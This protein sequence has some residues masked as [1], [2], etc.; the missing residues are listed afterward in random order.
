MTVRSVG[1]E[2]DVGLR[3][4]LLSDELQRGQTTRPDE[5][6]GGEQQHLSGR[7]KD[8]KPGDKKLCVC[9]CGRGV[10]VPGS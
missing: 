3:A 10:G 8:M 7:Q 2:P 9:V 1:L 4:E 6:Q 5:A